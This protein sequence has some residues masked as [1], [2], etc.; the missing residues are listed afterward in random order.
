MLERILDLIDEAEI[1]QVFEEL[2]KAGVVTPLLSQLKKE[3]I[4]GKTD[5][6]FYDR[7]KTAVRNVL[8]KKD[9]RFKI[10]N[11]TN[12]ISSY[13]LFIFFALILIGSFIV[14]CLSIKKYNPNFEKENFVP[15]M[16]YVEGGTFVMG[17]NSISNAPAH[18]VEMS[19]FC[20]SETEITVK[21]FCKF[22]YHTNYK[23]DA[24]NNGGSS[25]WR[26]NKWEKD[27][28]VHWDYNYEGKL[29]DK[30]EYN[31]PVIHVSWNDA[32]AYC[33]WLSD[34]TGKKYCLPTE[35]QWEYVA[36]GGQKKREFIYSGSNN[37][38]DVAWYMGTTGLT[39]T[40]QV[41]TKKANVL[42][43]FDMS[44]NAFEWCAD[45]YRHNVYLE[46]SGKIIK[47]PIIVDDNGKISKKVI[48][49]GAWD[50]KEDVCHISNRPEE[51]FSDSN[52]ST[53]FRIV[54][55]K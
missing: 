18:T 17:N 21:S 52:A 20:I 9:S 6:D 29:R 13:Y 4:S 2:D 50:S 3:F 49:G 55:K 12:V 26:L 47:D 27:P 48:R 30:S 43:V 42:G 10:S 45:T 31:H 1:A 46:R 34:S 24:E 33:K 53:G 14:Y 19:S 8:K 44:G 7:L 28:N 22:I 15:E 51:T 54:L 38:D 11:W 37:I 32:M 25:V 36:K 23:T 35:A 16:I 39:G 41:K 40:R 5:F